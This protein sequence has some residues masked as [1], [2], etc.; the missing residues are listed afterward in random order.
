MTPSMM[1]N[2]FFVVALVFLTGVVVGG[3]VDDGTSKVVAK[4]HRPGTTQVEARYTDRGLERI[5]TVR[6]DSWQV[7]LDGRWVTVDRADYDEAR[8]G[9]RV[10]VKR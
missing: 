7:R 9:E 1:L 10:R 6:P 5:R 2:A 4:R 3:C 8:V